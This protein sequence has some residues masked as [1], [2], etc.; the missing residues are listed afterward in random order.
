VFTAEGKIDTQT[1]FG[2]T[3]SGV[4]RLAQKHQVP[5]IALGGRVE[6]S[7][8][9]LYNQGVTAAFAIANGP[10]SLEESK[11]HAAE[12]L[13]ATSEQIMRMIWKFS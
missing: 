11:A 2:K 5:V 3:I 1:A 12:L 9:E 6:N 10:M 4:A 8:T 7:L 13:A